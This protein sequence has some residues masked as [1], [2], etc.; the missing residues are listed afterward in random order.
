MANN[1]SS[2]YVIERLGVAKAEAAT[3]LAEAENR[4]PKGHK[5]DYE[6]RLR[7]D[8]PNGETLN[9]YV[10]YTSTD[11]NQRRTR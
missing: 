1:T 6:M 11:T 3:L 4:C 2:R 8:S 9:L 10:W 7:K 5:T